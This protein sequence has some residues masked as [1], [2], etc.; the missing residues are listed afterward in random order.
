MIEYKASESQS[1]CIEESIKY[2]NSDNK[3]GGIFVIQAGAGAGKTST[4]IKIIIKL[5]EKNISNTDIKMFSFTRASALDIRMKIQKEIQTIF[6]NN[7]D[8]NQKMIYVD[9]IHTFA[10]SL[11]KQLSPLLSTI[12]E[13]NEIYK[14]NENESKGK[15][16]RENLSSFSTHLSD[17]IIFRFI[18]IIKNNAVMNFTFG[19]ELSNI[20]INSAKNILLKDKQLA[21]KGRD[22]DIETRTDDIIISTISALQDILYYTSDTTIRDSYIG[23][24]LIFDECQD[25]DLSQI[26]MIYS[27]AMLGCRIIVVGDNLQSL[28]RFRVG[29]GALFF[30]NITQ[31]NISELLNIDYVE[32]QYKLFDNFRSEDSIINIQNMFPLYYKKEI[33]KI[34]QDTKENLNKKEHIN[35]NFLD[36]I[37][38]HCN[39]NLTDKEVQQRYNKI[40][41][42]DIFKQSISLIQS[43]RN[44]SK[45][46]DNKNTNV[47]FDLLYDV[48][49][50]PD[51]YSIMQINDELI[52]TKKNII[53]DNKIILKPGILT[54]EY[55][56][57][58][59]YVNMD[60]SD[61]QKQKN[62]MVINFNIRKA[63]ENMFINVANGYSASMLMEKWPDSSDIINIY[64]FIRE[65]LVK[66]L[67]EEGQSELSNKVS[68]VSIKVNNGF[69]MPLSESHIFPHYYNGIYQEDVGIPISSL[70][71]MAIIS[72]FCG[73][74]IY[75]N[76]KWITLNMSFINFTENRNGEKII[77]VAKDYFEG[78]AHDTIRF[79]MEHFQL[80]L[81]NQQKTI[82]TK[83]IIEFMDSVYNQYFL[84]CHY[85]LRKN[86]LMYNIY[87]ILHVTQKNGYNSDDFSSVLTQILISIQNTN[88]FSERTI[89]EVENIRNI[90]ENSNIIFDYP[91]GYSS[92]YTF[93]NR[94]KN[95]LNF[96]ECNTNNDIKSFNLE[97]IKTGLFGIDKF[98]GEMLGHLFK[99]FINSLEENKDEI[100]SKIR[101]LRLEHEN[102]NYKNELKQVNNKIISTVFNR[103]SHNK[104]NTTTSIQSLFCKYKTPFSNNEIINKSNDNVILLTTIHGSKG[105]EWD[106]VLIFTPI[107]RQAM[108]K[109]IDSYNKVLEFVGDTFDDVNKIYVALSRAKKQL[110][111]I[112]SDY[113]S[114]NFKQKIIKDKFHIPQSKWITGR[115]IYN[116]FNALYG[117]EKINKI[118]ETLTCQK[119]NKEK[120]YIL[121]TSSSEMEKSSCKNALLR[122]TK[123]PISNVSLNPKPSFEQ[124]FHKL[125][126]SICSIIANIAINISEESN[127]N[128]IIAYK[129][130][131]FYNV[132][133]E[134]LK[135]DIEEWSQDDELI[136]ASII[137]GR[138]ITPPK[139]RS[140]FIDET[141]KKKRADNELL[142]GQY[143]GKVIVEHLKNMIITM[144]GS[145]MDLFQNL[146]KINEKNDFQNVWIEKEIQYFYP[147]EA[148]N[149]K[150]YVDVA[151]N[152]DNKLYVY[153]F[154]GIPIDMEKINT[155]YNYT[156]IAS[157]EWNKGIKQMHGYAQ[158]IRN[159]NIFNK[160]I[161]LILI[162]YSS[163]YITPNYLKQ[164][165]DIIIVPE[166]PS[167]NHGDIDKNFHN[168]SIA[169]MGVNFNNTD[170]NEMLDL[171]D[172]VIKFKE[173]PILWNDTKTCDL[174][175]NDDKEQDLSLCQKCDIKI[176]CG[177]YGKKQ[178]EILKQGE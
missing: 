72:A 109:G 177:Y 106:H 155:E 130:A 73:T 3:N 101:L 79:T 19:N 40:K 85:K 168:G 35:K 54:K 89:K 48:Q 165:K 90:F 56:I 5:L 124:N 145:D 127:V 15:I 24:Y 77:D 142:I 60:F 146:K 98:T 136:K 82:L 139:Y 147:D 144:Y 162:L 166:I 104:N 132:K 157:I 112:I 173:S 21:L 176:S 87:K 137:W 18:Q 83:I 115:V 171:L 103:L 26:L 126:A 16:L 133:H 61:V 78:Y 141:G 152:I 9:T 6:I 178:L 158:S 23:K 69:L 52:S 65:P 11:L 64:N 169:Q 59:D 13:P 70:C 99:N 71:L 36:D 46:N 97:I 75:V 138:T 88:I 150:G 108:N 53:F 27:L 167:N 29:I 38:K 22:R 156:Q 34:F 114:Q 161:Y 2:L 63:I 39:N 7:K 4:M 175:D 107:H 76:N 125:M 172:D 28:Y 92:N 51:D 122:A 32:T 93:N 151:I 174:K 102:S 25:L 30:D 159:K 111:I 50:E 153:D 95:V 105:L 143:Y 37:I 33:Q 100:N 154:K 10:N 135:K 62:E 80:E 67:L 42:H 8:L 123:L 128:E 74:N 45:K 110:D 41:K 164:N 31:K 117:N 148:I 81:T 120:K 84:N 47:F 91:E 113:H 57:N 20:N 163:P 170:F 96:I 116:L 66:K 94:L 134:N 86:G 49:D 68:N 140:N 149:T 121:T 44:K 131:K 14:F 1:K 17:D 55:L 160:N 58:E 43:Y 129:I 119:D 118:S 12:K